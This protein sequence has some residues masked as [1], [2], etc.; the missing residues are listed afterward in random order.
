MA[1]VEL[2][3]P[4]SQLGSLVRPT[5]VYELDAEHANTFSTYTGLIIINVTSTFVV[6]RT[7]QQLLMSVALRNRWRNRNKTR[8]T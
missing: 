6:C 8:R 7:L 4:S 1:F 3:D 5:L 2:K